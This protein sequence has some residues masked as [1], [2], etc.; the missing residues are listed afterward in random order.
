MVTYPLLASRI[1]SNI[2]VFFWWTIPPKLPSL[3]ETLGASQSVH[4]STNKHTVAFVAITLYNCVYFHI[5]LY[6][7]IMH[8]VVT[9]LSVYCFNKTQLC[10]V[11]IQT[12]LQRIA[13]NFQKMLKDWKEPKKARFNTKNCS[14]KFNHKFMAP[15][16]ASEAK[17]F[18]ILNFSE[19]FFLLNLAFQ[20]FWI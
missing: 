7:S 6:T 16:D 14:E 4:Y 2:K 9:I 5:L 11:S 10:A 18:E 12:K 1:D 20:S 3:T 8:Y 13:N 19:K 15:C 17:K